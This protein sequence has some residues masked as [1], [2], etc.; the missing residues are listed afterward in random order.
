MPLASALPVLQK[1]PCDGSGCPTPAISLQDWTAWLQKSDAQV[2]QRLDAGEEDSLT[3]LLRFGVTY[4]KEYRIDDEYLPLYGQSTLVN[5]FAENRANDLIKALA[6]PNGNQGFVEM[7][8]FLEKKGFSFKTPADRAQVK[9]YLLA[10]LARMRKEFLQLR[11]QAKTDRSHEF[12]RRGISLDSNLWPDYDLDVALQTL[13]GSGKLQPAGIRRVGIV[14]P[15][16]DFVNKQEGVDYYPPQITQP[17]AVLDTLFRLHLASP[18][19]VE[20]YTFDISP[21]VNLH[22][23]RAKK[24]AAHGR[25]YTVQLPWYS[26]GRWTGDFRA[27]FTS[28]WQQLGS[29]I[30]QPVT[31]IPVPQASPGFSTR[32]IRIRPAILN[33]VTPVDMNIVFQRLPLAPEQR[34]DLIIGT[35]IFLYYGSFE[36]ALACVNIASMLKSGGYLLSNDKLA[37]AAVAGLEPVMVSDIPMTTPPVITD[38]IYSY[39]RAP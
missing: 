10:N 19:T 36:Q 23:E 21:R 20:L 32:A 34:F 26:D 25:G 1:V 33:H 8:M 3:N 7:R 39:R 18:D 16:L 30:G 4:T 17:F 14:G 29:Q 11:A 6:A 15:G 38:Y 13:L 22:L 12:E 2:R 24:N 35:N 27:K 28:Y 37:D 9:A 5:A 31:P